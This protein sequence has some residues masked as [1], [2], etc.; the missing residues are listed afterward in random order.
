[1]DLASH[2]DAVEFAERLEAEGIAPIVR[3]WKYILIGTATE[4]DARELAE[5]LRGQVPQGA[6]VRPSRARPSATSSRRGARSPCSADSD[7]D[8]NQAHHPAGAH[9]SVALPR[10]PEPDRGLL[11]G[12]EGRELQ[13][14]WLVLMVACEAA[15]L[16]CVWALQR[17]CLGGAPLRAVITSQ[18]AGNALGKVAPGGGATGAALQY[19]MLVESGVRSA[20][21]GSGLAAANLLTFATLLALPVLTVPAFVAGLPVERGLVRAALLGAGLFVALAA[22]GGVLLASDRALAFVGRLAQRARNRVLRRR[23]PLAGLPERLVAER[24]RALEVIGAGARE[25]LMASVLRWMLDFSALLLALAA[26]GAEPR[27]SLALLAYA[28]AQVLSMIPLTPAAWV[29]VE[30]WSDRVRRA[31]RGDAA[32]AALA[33][34]SAYRLRHL[35]SAAAAC[36]RNRGARPQG[37][38]GVFIS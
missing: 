38:R 1:M 26:V 36:R 7:R 23:A 28:A 3:R 35:D 4:D 29:F 8:A 20:A 21:A 10:R 27:A 31:R 33:T 34:L 17:I 6:T 2:R 32:D 19:R 9:R 12:A 14:R 24:D 25:A 5:R 15:S 16:S 30:A 13:L 37:A 11:H 22:V 18:L